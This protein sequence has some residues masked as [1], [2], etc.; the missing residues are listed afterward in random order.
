M[1]NKLPQLKKSLKSFILDEDAKVIDKSVVKIALTTSFI[2][3]NLLTNMEDGNA[4]WGDKHANHSNHGNAINAPYN[5][6][7]GLHGGNNPEEVINNDI[8]AKSI[9]TVH[10]NHY[11][12]SDESSSYFDSVIDWSFG[13]FL[14]DD[15]WNEYNVDTEKLT[16]SDIPKVISKEIQ[17]LLKN[18]ER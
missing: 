9:E 18:E 16:L 15:V 12:H 5:Y 13:G 3:I 10:N 17:D 8:E 4:G 7:T 6:E 1:I 11:N 14:S 2:A